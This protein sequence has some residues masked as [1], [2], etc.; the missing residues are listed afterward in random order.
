MNNENNFDWRV[1]HET[2]LT[3]LDEKL[4]EN[5]IYETGNNVKFII[6]Q[7]SDTH[8]FLIELENDGTLTT[9]RKRFTRDSFIKLIN[10]K[11]FDLTKI[12]H[13]ETYNDLRKYDVNSLYKR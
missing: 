9:S 7:I 4:K 11:Y 1:H 12:S 2:A 10:N 3:K 8:V 5:Q 6:E 13:R